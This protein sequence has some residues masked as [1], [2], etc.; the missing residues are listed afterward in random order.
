MCDDTDDEDAVHTG[1]DV[2]SDSRGQEAVF[3]VT[4]TKAGRSKC[5]SAL[6][7]SAHLGQTVPIFHQQQTDAEDNCLELS[8]ADLQKQRLPVSLK[9]LP[10]HKKTEEA[11][12]SDSDDDIERAAA[13]YEAMWDSCA[14]CLRRH[15]FRYVARVT[16]AAILV[17]LV[18]LCFVPRLY[19]TVIA[20][21]IQWEHSMHA[22]S[23][24]TLEHI[25]SKNVERA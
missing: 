22:G 5:G 2:I 11:L 19:N 15:H 4:Y 3:T 23:N 14:S 20:Q 16:A 1:Y 6:R 24:G 25:Y 8:A 9:F 18:L 12:L 10:L 17:A 7:D 13:V 21:R